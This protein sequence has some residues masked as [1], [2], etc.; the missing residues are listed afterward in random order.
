MNFPVCL[1]MVQIK[2]H[3][4]VTVIKKVR[5]MLTKYSDHKDKKIFFSKELDRE[6]MKFQ[7]DMVLTNI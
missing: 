5:Y 7:R 6:K 1:G 3:R 4:D 2:E